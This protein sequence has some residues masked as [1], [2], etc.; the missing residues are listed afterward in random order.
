MPFSYYAR[1]TR[2]QQAIYRKSDEIAEVRLP[3][4]DALH[5]LVEALDGGARLRGPRG[6][7]SARPSG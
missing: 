4:P 3:R 6:D 5:P 2:S 7:R 1:L